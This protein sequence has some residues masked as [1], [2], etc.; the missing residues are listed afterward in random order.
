MGFNAGRAV[1]LPAGLP[2][3]SQLHWTPR[4]HSSQ[5][6]NTAKHSKHFSTPPRHR[7]KELQQVLYSRCG[8][9]YKEEPNCSHLQTHPAAVLGVHSGM[10]ACTPLSQGSAI[11][12]L[13]S[14]SRAQ[15]LLS[16]LQLIFDS[17]FQAQR[18]DSKRHI[19]TKKRNTGRLKDT[20]KSSIFHLREK[21]L[22]IPNN[23]L[24]VGPVARQGALNVKDTA[25]DTSRKTQ[26][27]ICNQTDKARL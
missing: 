22:Y 4:L 21:E 1:A 3:T 24:T 7:I 11:R 14:H 18:H 15:V 9:A 19:M 10:A 26:F 12:S 8:G 17:I 16:A 5:P 2:E 13:H 6:P 23:Q 27:P 20:E 25:Q